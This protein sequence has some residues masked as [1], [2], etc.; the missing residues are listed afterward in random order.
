MNETDEMN[1]NTPEVKVSISEPPEMTENSTTE[2]NQISAVAQVVSDIPTPPEE[3]IENS[4][5]V[6]P[7]KEETTETVETVEV[8][9]FLCRTS[10]T[11]VYQLVNA[12]VDKPYKAEIDL[13]ELKIESLS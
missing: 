3:I 9:L 11:G 7:E 6:E 2:E 12:M 10:E 1:A 5:L 13:K 8:P 4:A